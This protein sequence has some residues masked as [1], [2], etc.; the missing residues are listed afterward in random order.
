M[1]RYRVT[2]DGHVYD[3]EVDD[4]RVRP[5]VARI[6]GDTFLVDVEAGVPREIP[7]DAQ[8]A[9]ATVVPAPILAGP[10]APVRTAGDKV[11]TAPIPGTV[12]KVVAA[13]GKVVQRGDELLTIEAMKMFNVIRSPRAGAIAAVHVSERSR[14]SQGDLL[15]TFAS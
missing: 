14:V 12:V 13:A 11:L 7:E 4:P 9:A 10:A 6:E 15:V 8:P 3:V 1:R 2:V 5:V